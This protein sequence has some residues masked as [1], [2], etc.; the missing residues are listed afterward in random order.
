M[1]VHQENV[2]RN[3]L[4]GAG[5]KKFRV[6]SSDGIGTRTD[7]TALED[8]GS[9]LAKFR[10]RSGTGIFGEFGESGTFGTFGTLGDF[11]I[12]F[13]MFFSMVRN[14]EKQIKSSQF[15]AHLGARQDFVQERGAA[16]PWEAGRR[17]MQRLDSFG[18]TL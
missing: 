13:I 8:F 12:C 11:G 14:I 16:T 17:A 7:Q 5:L 4:I 9:A 15:W 1:S 10:N 3:N 6:V 2:K 18:I